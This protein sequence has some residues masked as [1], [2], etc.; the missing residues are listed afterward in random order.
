MNHIS[1]CIMSI[2]LALCIYFLFQL[3]LNIQ[4]KYF[5]QIVIFLLINYQIHT[6]DTRLY[7]A[8]QLQFWD[9]PYGNFGRQIY[10]TQ[11]VLIFEIYVGQISSRSQKKILSRKGSIVPQREIA[12][13]LSAQQLYSRSVLAMYNQIYCIGISQAK[14]LGYYLVKC[15]G[16]SRHGSYMYIQNWYSHNPTLVLIT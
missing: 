16:T 11:I 9:T 12:Q 10:V 1:L 6:K 3:D 2:I 7:K 15:S 13:Y 4:D 5:K 8:H 14:P